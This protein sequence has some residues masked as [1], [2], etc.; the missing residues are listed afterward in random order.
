MKNFWLVL[1]QDS[2]CL[3]CFHGRNQV[4]GKFEI[5]HTGR[6]P[7][8]FHLLLTSNLQGSVQRH[9]SVMTCRFPPFLN[10]FTYRRLSFSPRQ[11]SQ[12]F[13]RYSTLSDRNLIRSFPTTGFGHIS[14][15]DKFEEENLPRYHAERFYPVRIGDVY[16]DCYQIL[17]KLGFGTTST[18]WLCRDLRCVFH[19]PRDFQGM[20]LFF[21]C[22][23]SSW[24]TYFPKAE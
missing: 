16:N 13:Y 9:N 1:V 8:V 7:A 24:R 11:I 21:Q 20:A 17:A 18:I 15:D 10:L 3:I 6:S 4:F 12:Y 22:L 2:E 23:L 5:F 14:L 19:L